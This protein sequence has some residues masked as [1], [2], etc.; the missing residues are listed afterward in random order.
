MT[1]WGRPGDIADC[2]EGRRRRRRRRISLIF[3][4]IVT[5]MFFLKIVFHVLEIVVIDIINSFYQRTDSAV[6]LLHFIN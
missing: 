6:S 4:I 2:G 3:I 5:K 1:F